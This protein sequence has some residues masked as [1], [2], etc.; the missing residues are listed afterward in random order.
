MNLIGESWGAGLAALY[1]AE[2]SASVAR[3]V[4]LGPMPPTKALSQQ[5]FQLVDQSTGFIQ[6]MADLRRTLPTAPDPLALCRDFYRAYMPR[7]FA[8]PAALQRRKGDQCN[9][10]PE[11]FRNWLVVS[12]ATLQS[13]GDWD[14]MPILT[15]L[16]V[17]ALIVEGEVSDS[18]IASARAWAAAMP[19]S[20]LLLIPQSGHFPQVEQ[21]EIFFPAIEMFLKGAWPPNAVRTA[22]N[23]K[24]R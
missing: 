16:Q 18:N 6:R 14:F 21:P 19:D 24:R 22:Q 3:L 9:V 4:L 15:Q 17:P 20:G 23:Q 13:L 12:D 7:Y 5:R 11:G 1:T 10:P 2:H 8:D